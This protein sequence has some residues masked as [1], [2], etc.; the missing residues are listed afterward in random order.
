M[1]RHI[2]VPVDLAHKPSLNKAVTVA[3]DLAKHYGATLDF[4]AVTSSAP[5]AVASNPDA[6]ANALEMFAGEEGKMHGIEIKATAVTT[7]DP[8]VELN[9]VLDREIH[10][11]D[12]DLVVMA[13]HVPGFANYV[14]ASN[15]GYLASHT[16]ISVMVVR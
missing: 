7:P 2:L 8:A 12:A 16:D 5:G 14:F 15:A 3:A 6:F 4:V 9:S 11:H 10:E 1:Y 13:S